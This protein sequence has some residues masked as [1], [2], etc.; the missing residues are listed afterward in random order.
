MVQRASHVTTVGRHRIGWVEALPEGA[1][2]NAE[3]NPVVLI[4]GLGTS[5]AWW[6]PTIAGLGARRR[7]L[8]VDLPGFGSSR[9]QPFRLDAAADVVAAWLTE[10]GVA[11]ADVVG[12]SMGGFVAADLASRRPDLVGRLVLV[13]AAGLPIRGRVSG[14]IRNV[15][16]GGV[17]APIAMYPVALGCVVRAGPLTIARAAHQILASDATAR[18]GR[19]AAPTLVVWGARDELLPASFGRRLAAA[20]PG[21]RYLEIASAGHSPMWEAANEF[22]HAL[23]AF[24]DEPSA[25]VLE[26]PAS[27]AAAAPAPGA[28]PTIVTSSTGGRVVSR[29]LA[30]G[31]WTIHVRV[32]RPDHPVDTPPIVF[33]HGFVIST[34]SHLPTMRRLAGRHLVFAPD[35]PGFGWSSKPDDVLDVPGL[36]NALVAAMDAA[37][38]GRAVL[39]GSSLGSQIAAQV[40]VDHPDRVLATVLSGPTFDPT[41]PS[42]AGHVLRLLADMPRERPSLWAAAL[43]DSV[44]AGPRR[45]LT[46]LRHAWTH[47]IE[48]VLPSVRT[49]T[50]VVRGGRD[51]LVPRPWARGAASLAGSRARALEVG[52]AAHAVTFGAPRSAARIV[53][54]LVASLAATARPR[55]DGALPIHIVTATQRRRPAARPRRARAGPRR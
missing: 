6:N 53:D 34:R 47:R 33:V 15:V 21:A 35:L 42:L 37:A 32:G 4:H 7:V 45:A 27:A 24:L 49:P 14:H 23:E 36:G 30:V 52:G 5:G 12:H 2:P 44:L 51:P 9:G 22:E 3:A 18:L 28:E 16:R 48:R 54:D 46:T 13:D 17:R 41:E 31:D 19:I 1:A 8:L 25:T 11:R 10:I 55:D 26:E 43:R 39:V 20:I 40:A 50:V 29:Y 38:I